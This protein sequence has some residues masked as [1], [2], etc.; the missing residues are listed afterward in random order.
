MKTPPA[1][2]GVRQLQS[3]LGLHGGHRLDSGNSAYPYK[4][5]EATTEEIALGRR[6]GMPWLQ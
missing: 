6:N 1:V 4:N 3:V 2:K 5:L